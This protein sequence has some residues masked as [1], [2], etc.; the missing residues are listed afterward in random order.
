M[1]IDLK[2]DDGISENIGI[3]LIVVVAVVGV[4]VVG[5]T[6]T[7][8]DTPDEV[9]N[10]DMIIGCDRSR[11]NSSEYNITLFH[12]GEDTLSSGEFIVQ[13]LTEDGKELQVSD[14]TESSDNCWS[15]GDTAS[16]FADGKPASIRILYTAG[17]AGA[18][19]KSLNLGILDD[20]EDIPQD[21]FVDEAG[22]PTATPTVTVTPTVTSTPVPAVDIEL[23]TK[24]GKKG[25]IQENSYIQF[26]VTGDYS[27]IDMTGGYRED[28]NKN[29]V[30]KLVIG[31]KN[32][33]SDGYGT[34]Y[35]TL[36][37][38]KPFAFKNVLLYLN[39]N[40]VHE[41]TVKDIWISGYDNFLS[42]LTIS[43]PSNNQQTFFKVDSN[44]LID[45][46]YDRRPINI[47]NLK[48][49]SN[50]VMNF[51]NDQGKDRIYYKGGAESYEII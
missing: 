30:V 3:M 35:M 38:I 18:M 40:P 21:V 12:N 19:L 33:N 49:G 10:V 9:P 48:P 25:F 26:R 2:N 50:G 24:N 5:V 39:G 11:V 7:S 34:I 8:Q 17:S 15:I 16:Y 22:T 13:A 43:V 42:T 37:Q 32:G 47:Y 14:C 28:F 46:V 45:W 36:S 23:N 6:V 31:H 4:A 20:E 29:D 27:Y 44:V 51:D 41:G 1:R